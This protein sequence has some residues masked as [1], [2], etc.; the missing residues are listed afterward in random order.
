ML[1]S[2]I[3]YVSLEFKGEVWAGNADLGIV[4]MYMVH[5]TTRLDENTKGVSE[6]R[7]R[8]KEA[9]NWAQGYEEDREGTVAG[10]EEHWKRPSGKKSFSEERKTNCA[11]C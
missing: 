2:Q 3:G 4:S 5:E 6:F 9:K 11:N 7:E 1:S 10:Q 8:R